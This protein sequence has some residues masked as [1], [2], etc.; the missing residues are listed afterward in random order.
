MASAHYRRF[1]V[2]TPG[3]NR[4]ILNEVEGGG[5][6]TPD[7]VVIGIYACRRTSGRAPNNLA[8]LAD[9]AGS[10]LLNVLPITASKRIIFRQCVY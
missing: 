8:A 2:L 4:S 3:N 6:R 10:R 7:V 9:F 1:Q 5:R